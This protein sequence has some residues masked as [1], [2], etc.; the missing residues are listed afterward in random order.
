MSLWTRWLRRIG[1]SHQNARRNSKSKSHKPKRPRLGVDLLETRLVPS[2][3]ILTNQLDYAPGSTAI[4]TGSGFQPGE[5]VHLEV[6]RSDGTVEGTPDNPWTI[7]DGGQGDLDGVANGQFTTTWYVD[8]AY[9]TNQ[10]LTATATGLSSGE[11]ASVTFTD[12]NPSVDNHSL[13]VSPNSANTAPTITASITEGGNPKTNITAAE[14]F[15]D[16]TGADGTGTAMTATGTAFNTTQTSQGVTATLTAAQFNGLSQGSHTISVHGKDAT[17]WGTFD[18][19]TFIKDTVAPSLTSVTGPTNGTYAIGQTLNFTASFSEVVTVTGTPTIGLTIGST[20]RSASYV[21]GSGTTALSFQYTVASG[22]SDTDGITSASPINL[23]G[24]SIKDAAGNAAASLSFTAPNTTGVLV[25]GI[26]PTITSVTPPP[27]GSYGIGAS[28]NFTV[29]YSENVTEAGGTAPWIVLTIGS[30]SRNAN[31]VSGSG[32][33]ALL[34]SYTVVSGDNDTDG[35][36]VA[37]PISLNTSG[38]NPTSIKDAAGNNAVLTFTAP[39]TT[40][41]LVDGVAPLAPTNLALVASDDTGSSSS[42]RI[43]SV[44]TPTFTGKAEANSTVELFRATTISLGTATADA[45]GNWSI[46][47]SSALPEGVN[48]ITA[49]ATDAAGNTGPASTALSV[50][51]DSVVPT[52]TIATSG[53]YSAS[54]WPTAGITGTANG[55]GSNVQAV[56]VS[57]QR[58]SDGLYWNGSS[59]ASATEVFNS[60]TGTTS[61]TY[62][63]SQPADGSYTVHSRAT[64]VAGNVQTSLTSSSFTV[65][66]VAPTSAITFPGTGLT[67]NANGWNAG[68]GTPTTGDIGGIASDSGSGLLTVAVSIKNNTSGKYWNGSS[69][70]TG[71]GGTTEGFVPVTAGTTSWTYLF[72]NTN[73]SIGVSY[74]IHVRGTDNA[75]N[76]EAVG[77]GVTFTYNTSTGDS[78]APTISLLA[79]TPA[80]F[81]PNGDGVKDMKRFFIAVRTADDLT[82]DIV[83]S[84]GN[85]VRRLV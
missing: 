10:T 7:T 54:T 81:S 40:G 61:W 3:T 18:S 27:N 31:Y 43:T 30:T 74:T 9:A 29:N 83:D 63:F 71:S 66:T 72:N 32:T 11:T 68:N 20:A 16:G 69:F 67:Y 25:D 12:G 53:N 77:A 4:I 55:T 62:A 79:A 52:S 82:V 36:T 26:A 13:V 2:A 48:S 64:D 23:N 14:Y 65:D 21:S 59:F 8:P 41:V 73:L 35:I 46:T 33:S 80:S 84:K 6:L 45:S 50:T 5:S 57:I 38:G 24:G 76:V 51:I 56:V 75:G 15:I 60:V 28:L 34:F 58:A 85:E 70:P 37:S 1:T 39:N 22:D 78:T 17:T 19:T 44:K 42:D 47:A 49:Q